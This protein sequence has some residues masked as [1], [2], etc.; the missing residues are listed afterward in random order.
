M[1][2]FERIIVRQIPAAIVYEDEHTV[3][4]KDIN[5]QAPVHLLVVPRRVLAKLAD[6]TDDDTEMLG[7]CLQGARRAAVAAG[8][9]SYRV[10]IN[11]GEAAGQTVFH[12]HLHVIG[13]RLLDWPPG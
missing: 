2:L 8:L 6:A 3:A 13:G 12:L 5:P 10:V 4:F 7:H 9:S 1:T 11:C